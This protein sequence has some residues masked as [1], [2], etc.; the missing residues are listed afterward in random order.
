[1]AVDV[2]IPEIG[3]S[4]NEGFLAEWSKQDGAT[5]AAEEPLL[6]LETDKITMNVTAE[7]AGK[8]EILVAEGESVQVGQVVARINPAAAGDETPIAAETAPTEPPAAAV[9]EVPPPAA[10][11]S[12][13]PTAELS[14]LSPAVR[15]LVEENKLDPS[16]IKGTG[17]DGRILK[18][19]VLAFMTTPTTAAAEAPAPPTAAETAPSPPTPMPAGMNPQKLLEK[20]ITTK[21]PPNRRRPKENI[22][23][24]CTRFA[25]R[26]P[27]KMRALPT[28]AWRPMNRPISASSVKRNSR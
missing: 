26:G 2:T 27:T 8:L 28:A 9:R 13:A 12:P 20:A 10:E 4:I 15:R 17:K 7:V 19:D 6:V 23:P 14:H 11:S 3:E 18:G 21:P 1:M 16:A 22:R 5:V 25:S 24:R